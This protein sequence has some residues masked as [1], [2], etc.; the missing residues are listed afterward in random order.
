L[1]LE[2]LIDVE[3]MRPDVMNLLVVAKNDEDEETQ[4]S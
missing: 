2:Q 3:V 1:Y 4:A